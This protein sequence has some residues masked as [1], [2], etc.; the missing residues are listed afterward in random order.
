VSRKVVQRRKKKAE[1]PDWIKEDRE[2]KKEWRRRNQLG[3]AY[4]D[5]DK[6]LKEMGYKT[7][8]DY[9]AGELWKTIK[10]AGFEKHGDTC[11]LCPKK[12]VALHHVSYCMD[13]LKGL[14]LSKLVPL[15]DD[16]HYAVEFWP[17]GRK[18][19]FGASLKMYNRFLKS[20]GFHQFIV[21][22]GPS[23]SNVCQ[24]CT[25]LAKKYETMCNLCRK[26]QRRE[27]R[28]KNTSEPKEGQA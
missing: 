28:I 12:A 7:Y 19:T 25:N 2:R 14:D 23:S 20:A 18:R 16:C 9:L 22:I 4:R 3:N 15:C 8:R 21:G 26:K 11:R 5:R 24:K 13:V 1:V 10:A 27:D 17:S 6:L